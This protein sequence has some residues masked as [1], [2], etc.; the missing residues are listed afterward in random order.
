[1]IREKLDN[2]KEKS[3]LKHPL[4]DLLYFRKFNK[5][6]GGRIRLGMSGAAPMNGQV[7]DRLKVTIGVNFIN[8]YGQTEIAGAAACNLPEDFEAGHVGGPGTC[9]EIKLVDIPEM[10]YSKDNVD[11]NGEPAPSGEIC[12]R[13]ASVLPKYFKN[14]V[15]TEESFDSLGWL[16]TGDVGLLRKN[17]TIAVIDRKKSLLKLSQGEYVSPEKIENVYMQSKYV[18]FNFVYGNPLQSYLVGIISPDKMFVEPEAKRLG[19]EDWASACEDDRIKSLILDDI[20]QTG[21]RLGLNSIEQVKRIHL[22]PHPIT[23]DMGLLTPTFKMKRKELREFF[24]NILESLYLH[25]R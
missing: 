12:F 3:T 17:G 18:S 20:H 4:Y 21:Q 13:G 16:H 10:G 8:A 11:E 25:H 15:A 2:M 19:I 14:P 1:M 22:V 7:L 23:P 6:F 24:G 5:L 9:L